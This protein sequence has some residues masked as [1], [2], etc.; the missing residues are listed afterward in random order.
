MAMTLEQLETENAAL[1]RRVQQEI[2]QRLSM[3]AQACQVTMAFSQMRLP[4]IEQEIQHARK[5]LADL[6]PKESGNGAA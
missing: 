3:E 6:M 2:I 1:K 4:M 5:A